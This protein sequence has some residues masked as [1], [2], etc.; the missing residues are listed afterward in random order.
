M[1]TTLT[2]DADAA[3]AASP[4]PW[5]AAAQAWDSHSPMLGEW[6]HD[7][8]QALL[9]ATGIG[10]GSR[11]LDI[12]AGAGDQTL[13]IA[14]RVGP[15]GHVLATDISPRIL[16]LAREKLRRAGLDGVSTRIADAEALGLADAGFDAVVCRMGLMLCRKPSAALAGAWSALQRGGRFGAVVFSAP[17]GNPYV[18]IMVSTAMRH[19]G[20]A[21]ASSFAPGTLLSLGQPGLMAELL[22]AAGFTDIHVRAVQ[23]PM[24]LPSREHYIDFVRSAGLAI[25]ALLAPLPAAAQRDAW[26][27]IT[28]QLGRFTVSAGWQGPHELLLCIATR[29]DRGSS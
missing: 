12:A 21:P 5:D 24:Q 7:V 29:P 17:A 25:M 23:A 13:D 9:D 10:P 8:T 20:L 1:M 14:R 19:A 27:D 15:T 11:V 2:D 18:A 16:A 4:H 26:Q 28:H 22:S 3:L 6:L